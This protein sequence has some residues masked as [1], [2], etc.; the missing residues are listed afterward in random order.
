MSLMELVRKKYKTA[1]RGADKTDISPYV[2][3]GSPTYEELKSQFPDIEPSEVPVVIEMLG[4]QD[5]RYRGI[6]PE[7][8]TATTECNR[9]G[10][11]PIFE[12]CPPQI[13]GCPWC[14]NRVKGLPMPAH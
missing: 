10:P 9:C 12:G 6:V 1:I 4:I 2:S 14:F 3:N 7:H 5:M 13:D 11:I 8:Y